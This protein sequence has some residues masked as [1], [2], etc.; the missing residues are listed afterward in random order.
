MNKIVR[1]GQ[2]GPNMV[3]VLE[4]VVL[5]KRQESDYA[6]TVLLAKSA[7]IL[8]QQL[9]KQP[10]IPKLVRFGLTGV[11]GLSVVQHAHHSK[12]KTLL[13]SAE[14]G[15]AFSAKSVKLVVKASPKSCVRVTPKYV[16]I[17]QIGKRLWN[18]VL[19]AVE[20]SNSKSVSV[21]MEFLV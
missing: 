10:V 7:V 3:P 20:V 19:H 18:V 5:V 11:N 9:M 17:G 2:N 4:H 21:L 12:Q 6:K 13:N 15:V 14:N 8:G 16:L 1:D